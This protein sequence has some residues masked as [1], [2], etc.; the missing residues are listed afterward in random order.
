MFAGLPQAAH[1]QCRSQKRGGYQKNIWN[2]DVFFLCVCMRLGYGYFEPVQWQ[3]RKKYW[4]GLCVLM[5]VHKRS[6]FNYRPL[7]KFEA[8]IVKKCTLLLLDHKS[9]NYT[10][11]SW[12]SWSHNAQRAKRQIHAHFLLTR[13]DS[14]TCTL[15]IDIVIVTTHILLLPHGFPKEQLWIIEGSYLTKIIFFCLKQKIN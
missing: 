3:Y 12:Q 9:C 6:A 7:W 5:S 14:D 11:I 2:F 15:S 8:L 4:T 13:A 1:C 10:I